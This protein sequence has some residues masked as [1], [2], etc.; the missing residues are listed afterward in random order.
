M[1]LDYVQGALADI[2]APVGGPVRI[3]ANGAV[4]TFW[5]MPR[6]RAFALGPT[7]CAVEMVMSDDPQTLLEPEVDLAIVYAEVPPPGW[8]G[9]RLMGEELA[10]VAAPD[11][12]PGLPLLDYERHA[13]D[14]I[15]WDVWATRHPEDP[16]L[17]RP[18]TVCRTYAQSIG[19]AISGDGIAL[20]S[21]M[22]L[23]VELASGALAPLTAPALN[24]GKGYLLITRNGA[25]P[26]PDVAVLR[27]A[28]GGGP[29]PQTVA[30]DM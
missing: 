25:E 20:A 2:R 4:S 22:L 3:S 15:N 6:L 14:W 28:L 29:N 10:P 16:L 9:E 30:N 17:S 13:P 1:A 12:A 5:L 18:R 23:E 19:R 27:A 24:T 21:C 8:S 26:R 7:A 11:A